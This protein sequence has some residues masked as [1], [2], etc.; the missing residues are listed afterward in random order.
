MKKNNKNLSVEA[1]EE[2]RVLS[3]A[4]KYRMIFYKKFIISRTTFIFL[5]V[6]ILIISSTIMV[7]N[8]SSIR[9]NQHPIETLG[10]FIGIATINVMTTFVITIQSFLN[11]TD[12][13]SKVENKIENIKNS[14]ETLKEQT[15]VTQEDVDLLSEIFN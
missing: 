6:I 9:F 12:A 11:I 8:L 15:D 7:L 5:S 2:K 14:L 10:L 3:K 1:L 4:S 13:K